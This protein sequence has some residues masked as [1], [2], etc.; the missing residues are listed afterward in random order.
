M[1]ATLSPPEIDFPRNVDGGRNN[2]FDPGSPGGGDGDPWGGRFPLRHDPYQTA[3][4]V[5]LIPVV[6][7]FVGLTSSMVVRRGVSDDWVSFPF[8]RIV[9]F[10]TLVLVAS[11]V[12]FELARRALRASANAQLRKWLWV[13]TALGLVFLAAQLLTWR[14]L[15]AHGVFVWSNP[16]G[17]FFYILTASHGAHLAGGLIALVYLT[18]RALREEL[19]ARRRSALRAAAVFW[20]FMDGLWIYL[21]LLLVLWR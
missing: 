10:S 16:S 20:H 13:T 9:L 12:T 15:A 7:F 19:T 5:F 2:P 1:S 17:A 11:S 4:W 6:M 8:P 14:D 18:I 3:I 21:L